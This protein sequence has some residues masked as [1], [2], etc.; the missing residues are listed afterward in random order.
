[1]KNKVARQGVYGTWPKWYWDLTAPTSREDVQSGDIDVSMKKT[2]APLLLRLQWQGHPLTHS[3]EHKWLYPLSKTMYNDEKK[4]GIKARGAPVTLNGGADERLARHEENVYF[5]LPHPGGEGKNVGNPMA[6]SFIKAIETGELGPEATANGDETSAKAAFDA[7]NMN[8]L[9]SY[10]IS[11]R[12][13]IMDQMV[14]YS[15]PSTG[16]ILPQ[17][18]TMGTVTRRAVEATWLTA[19]NAKKNRIGS[20]LKAMIR[21]PPGHAIVGADVDSEELWISSVMGDSQFGM[22]GATAIGWMTLEGT[23]S[24]GTDL[25]SKTANI[26]GIS[27]DA[28]K[29]FNYSRIYGAGQ[30][31]AVQ[32]LM[33]GDAT[34]SKEKAAKLAR[35]LYKATKGDKVMRDRRLAPAA[36]PSIWHGG[37]ESYLFNILEAIALSDRPMTPALGCGL[38]KALSKT[39]LE[40][41]TAYLPSRINWVVQSSGVDYLHLLIVSMEYLL[42]K[43]EIKARYLISVHDEVRY[44]AQDEDRYRTALALQIANA[45]TRALFCYNLGM[46]DVPQGVAFFSAVDVDHVLRKEV[47]MTCET[48]SHPNPIPAGESL[49]IHQVLEKTGGILGEPIEDDLARVHDT[50]VPVVLFPDIRSPEHQKYLRIQA[51]N[52]PSNTRQWLDGL[53]DAKDINGR[54]LSSPGQSRP[55]S[56]IAAVRKRL[57]KRSGRE[58]DR[59]DSKLSDD[60]WEA[61][62]A[63]YAD[64]SSA[65]RKTRI[66]VPVKKVPS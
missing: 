28:A 41:G 16:M 38:T 14:V 24:A 13:R 47:F 44:L 25:H 4:S 43:Y 1:M 63:V 37:S 5:R 55:Q 30:K 62:K 48:P 19:S 54:S 46:D 18:I 6:K 8:I 51:E 34:L 49:D 10:W 12:E 53:S 3:R 42:R 20:E 66:A 11:A 27:R 23:K 7:T 64:P 17:V 58:R 52:R 26:L 2:I 59:D 22:H 45:W 35:E 39:Y 40:E 15:D 60:V 9:C 36:I 50:G 31:H 33:Q 21:A 29:V 32:L 57:A 65:S 61:A 56:Q